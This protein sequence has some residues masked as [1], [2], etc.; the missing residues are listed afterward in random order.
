LLKAQTI[1]RWPGQS[2]QYSA[3]VISS[4]ILFICIPPGGDNA[5]L[6]DWTGKTLPA[7]QHHLETAGLMDKNR[8]GV[9]R[10]SWRC[11]RPL[12]SE[13]R[14]KRKERAVR[15]S[16]ER[17]SSRPL[18]KSYRRLCTAVTLFAAIPEHS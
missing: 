10:D 7:L 6:K 4:A 16:P 5:T 8:K 11:Y 15:L 13:H 3:T 1:Q 12:V 9:S 14:L 2:R 17:L 18:G